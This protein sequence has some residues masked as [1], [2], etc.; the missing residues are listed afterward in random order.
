MV[1][2][3]RKDDWGFPRWRPYGSTGGAATTRPCDR[4][5]CDGVGDRPAPK[6]PNS[7]ERWMFCEAHAAEYNK[8][9]DYFEG[10][11]AEDA[12]AREKSESGETAYA[13]S[14]QWGWGG[15]GDGTRTRAEMDALRVLEL[16]SDAT[17]ADVKT[18]YRTHAKAHHPDR[19]IGDK[20]AAKRFQAV[21]AA[22]EIL[23]RAAERH[24][25][26]R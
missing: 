15:A 12:K 25:A 18:A 26:T 7:P 2:Q 24:A 16:E 4:Y 14:A 22:Y 20:E 9:W 6:S 11:S 17:E 10:L 13:S 1:K 5:G 23:Q 3:T 21:Q 19:N 8:G